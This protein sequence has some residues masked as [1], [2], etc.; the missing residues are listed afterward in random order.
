MIGVCWRRRRSRLQKWCIRW[1]I[2]VITIDR[3]DDLFYRYKYCH[4]KFIL[5]RVRAAGVAESRKEGVENGYLFP[6]EIYLKTEVF[7]W[8][9]L[10]IL[11]I[12]RSI[13]E[14]FTVTN[15]SR[16]AHFGLF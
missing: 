14:I 5:A 6:R 12:L 1:A 11:F 10:F 7:L 9:I 2:G 16:E 15:L 13:N 8:S 4:A 3:I